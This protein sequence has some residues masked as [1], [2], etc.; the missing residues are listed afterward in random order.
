MTD[1]HGHR[2]NVTGDSCLCAQR[3][4]HANPFSPLP[5]CS[6]THVERSELPRGHAG[7]HNTSHSNH[8]ITFALAELPDGG[9]RWE[10]GL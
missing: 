7:T 6:L 8:S 10:G 3:L 2:R 9:E 5:P 1:L 4:D